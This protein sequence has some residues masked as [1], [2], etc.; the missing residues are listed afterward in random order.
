VIG[1]PNRDVDGLAAADGLARRVR[2]PGAIGGRL[3]SGAAPRAAAEPERERLLAWRKGGHGLS[4]AGGSD[5]NSQPSSAV[6][7]EIAACIAT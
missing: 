4:L 1:H 5:T 2:G 3:P 6:L 7:D